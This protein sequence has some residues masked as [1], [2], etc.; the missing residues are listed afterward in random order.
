MSKMN[1]SIPTGEDRAIKLRSQTEDGTTVKSSQKD[2][3]DSDG[4]VG[5][6]ELAAILKVRE[7]TLQG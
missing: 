4:V 5:G 6:S 1:I 7:H 3:N 2:S